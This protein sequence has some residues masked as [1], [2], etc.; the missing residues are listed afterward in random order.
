MLSNV[1]SGA[2]EEVGLR[3]AALLHVQDGNMLG[4]QRSK[5][6]SGGKNVLISV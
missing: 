1:Q 5:M 4:H 3:L 6:G 2:H